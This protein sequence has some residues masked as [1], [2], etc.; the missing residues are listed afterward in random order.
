[1]VF[2]APGSAHNFE[3]S[4]CVTSVDTAYVTDFVCV[5]CVKCE[6]SLLLVEII[7][8][9]NS[10]VDTGG[11]KS[12]SRACAVERPDKIVQIGIRCNDR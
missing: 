7:S 11:I 4:R 5:L 8:S 6:I 1:M 3:P 9:D 12:V 10:H 2:R